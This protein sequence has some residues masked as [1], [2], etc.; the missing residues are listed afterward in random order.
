MCNLHVTRLFQGLLGFNAWIDVVRMTNM[1]LVDRLSLSDDSSLPWPYQWGIQCHR[2]A[3][4]QLR[5]RI[6]SEYSWRLLLCWW[7]I[8]LVDLIVPL[9]D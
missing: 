8:L 4:M 2:D 9:L 7:L 3:A 5:I 1:H 6:M